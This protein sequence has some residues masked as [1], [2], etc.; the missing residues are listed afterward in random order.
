HEISYQISM[1]TSLR[2]I[3]SSEPVSI[4][5]HDKASA[6]YLA[7]LM[8]G[9]KIIR[10][11]KIQNN[12]VLLNT[13]QKQKKKS[14]SELFADVDITEKNKCHISLLKNIY[15]SDSYIA[16][17]DSVYELF[18]ELKKYYTRNVVDKK[19]GIVFSPGVFDNIGKTNDNVLCS[20]ILVLDIDDGD[21]SPLEFKK[22]FNED[23]KFSCLI[24]NTYSTSKL[25][26]NRYRVVFAL[27]RKVDF[28]EYICLHNY[29]QT[30][31][32]GYGY[33][34]CSKQDRKKFEGVKFSGIDLTK[35]SPASV[36]YMPCQNINHID[37]AFFI[38]L[39]SVN[40]QDFVRHTIK[41]D[42]VLN[43]SEI[44]V[45]DDSKLFDEFLKSMPSF[46]EKPIVMSP[47]YGIVGCY[48]DNMNYYIDIQVDHS[49]FSI[50]FRDR[51]NN[52]EDFRSNI[53]SYQLNYLFDDVLLKYIT[54]ESLLQKRVRQQYKTID[55][56]GS[57]ES[58]NKK[59]DKYTNEFLLNLLITGGYDFHDHYL[60]GRLAAAMNAAGFTEQ[61]FRYVI[62]IVTRG[63]SDKEIGDVWNNWGKYKNITKGT[64]LYMLGLIK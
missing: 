53:K 38:R 9:C 44:S 29:I 41:V 34:T 8:I 7:S 54:Q 13:Y 10:L 60:F 58:I 63:K 52:K 31:I 14:L 57:G 11:G 19:D 56:E 26:P 49:I 15:T 12:V 20:D 3:L 39:H 46:V 47:E 24:M 42:A 30:I 43:T 55:I 36:F 27:D 32:N 16:E 64:L 22:I 62:P 48:W 18:G 5:V 2:D 23:H 40:K 50:Y 6:N 25:D 59:Y 4:Y 35:V 51:L 61:D 33:I 1:R 17:T 28:D 45:L 37:S 21:L